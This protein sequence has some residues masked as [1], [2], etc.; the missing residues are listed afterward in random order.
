MKAII[1]KVR[2]NKITIPLAKQ[3]IKSSLKAKEAMESTTVNFNQVSPTFLMDQALE[4]GHL[5]RVVGPA[6]DKSGR[7]WVFLD[8]GTDIRYAV[9]TPDFIPK[10]TPNT[11]VTTIGA[12]GLS[13]FDFDN[14]RPGIEP[15]LWTELLAK[16][17]GKMFQERGIKI[18]K[19]AKVFS[20]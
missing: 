7:I 11:L 18:I 3:L 14:P 10:T 4:G 15:R 16:V 20:N 13:H 5:I 19:T 17:H 6:D 1:A 12:G 9:M 8:Q 2:P